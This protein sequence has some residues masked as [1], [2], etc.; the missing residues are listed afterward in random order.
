MCVYRSPAFDQVLGTAAAWTSTRLPSPD[1][2]A[3]QYAEITGRDL[4]HW[5]FYLA[6]ANFKL[7]VIAEGIAHRAT[8]KARHAHS[9]EPAADSTPE[10]LAQGLRFVTCS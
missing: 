2:I 10:L 6:L 1:E 9:A 4:T 3:Q 7:A 5:N 8:Q